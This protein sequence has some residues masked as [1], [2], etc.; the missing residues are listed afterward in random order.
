MKLCLLAFAPALLAASFAVD[1]NS[2]YGAELIGGYAITYAKEGEY[3]AIAT[4]SEYTTSTNLVSSESGD[5]ARFWTS[6]RSETGPWLNKIETTSNLSS[7]PPTGGLAFA[8]A[9][10][11]Y[12]VNGV[13]TGPGT[14]ATIRY[15][16]NVDGSFT[17]GPNAFFP[18]TSTPQNL[19]VYLAGYYGTADEILLQN[20]VFYLRSEGGLTSLNVLPEHP[21]YR[22]DGA[23]F[24]IPGAANAAC[25]APTFTCLSA[26]TFNNQPLEFEVDLDVGRPFTVVS[27]VSAYTNG[28]TDFFGTVKLQSITLDPAF[29]LTS[30]DGGALTRNSDGSYAL[31]A[32]AVPEPATWTMMIF[33][34]AGIGF[35]MRCRTRSTRLSVA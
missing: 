22:N 9:L 3:Q 24:M 35:S 27:L 16:F 4:S 6:A 28:Q 33:G 26:T 5:V 18:Q 21:G 31:A 32:T 25:P 12:A 29:T 34:L 13:V 30:D 19:G 2:A 10:S 20:D 23:A 15:T 8:A 11:L 7:P 1:I 14:T 17:P